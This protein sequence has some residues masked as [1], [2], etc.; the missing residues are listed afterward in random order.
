MPV[1]A[2]GMR[3]Q[4]QLN[5]GHYVGWWCSSCSNSQ[6][7][8]VLVG[9]SL[10]NNRKKPWLLVRDFLEKV[11]QVGRGHSSVFPFLFSSQLWYVGPS[12]SFP[13]GDF[14]ALERTAL[15][16]PVSVS[17]VDVAC[18]PLYRPFFH[19]LDVVTSSMR[20]HDIG[21]CSFSFS[22]CCG[23]AVAPSILPSN[24]LARSL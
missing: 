18:R 23:Y 19:I 24:N 7:I 6:F 21:V 8:G 10:M 14:L 20:L 4:L 22:I 9:D 5:K 12:L 16:P 13:A 11:G 3:I 15:T 17:D 2:R 1:R